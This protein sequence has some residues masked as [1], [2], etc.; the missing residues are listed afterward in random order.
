[1]NIENFSKLNILSL[2]S[3]YRTNLMGIAMLWIIFSHVHK[4]ISLPLFIK[5][6]FFGLGFGGVEIFLFCAGF[7]VYFSL[8]K[9]SD[10]LDFY[11]RRIKRFL[12]AIPFFIAF[13]FLSKI[14]S[15]HVMIGYFTYQSFWIQKSAFAYLSYI[16]LFYIITPIFYNIINTRLYDLKKQIYFL[17]LLFVL[18]IPY[19]NDWRI[20]GIARIFSFVIG[21]YAAYW[22][23]K[24]R[25]LSNKNLFIIL[26]ISAF[27]FI[28]LIITH[29][30]FYEYRIKYGLCYYL[31]ALFVPGL[32]LS[33]CLIYQK[34]GIYKDIFYF[35]GEKSL[36]IFLVD[37]MVVMYLKYISPIE[38][39]LI[40]LIIGTIYYYFYK[41]FSLLLQNIQK[42]IIFKEV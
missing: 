36:E 7:G 13:F 6:P 41:K 35:I 16:F 24:K 5:Y 10:I 4:Q 31:M 26:L 29:S 11:L 3:T 20:S 19:W 17:L 38:H 23:K 25:L 22:C 33:I 15:I 27:A 30:L 21:M 14:T 2:I 28:G 1:M 39:I 37:S 12:P 9:N 34:T 8:Y 40:S 42:K 32:V 18:T